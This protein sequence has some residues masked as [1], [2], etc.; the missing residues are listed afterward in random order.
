MMVAI[1]QEIHRHH[2]ETL[3]LLWYHVE[4]DDHS[5]IMYERGGFSSYTMKRKP[6]MSERNRERKLYVS[7]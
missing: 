6:N 2:G 7:H 5:S 3:G 4:I 1:I